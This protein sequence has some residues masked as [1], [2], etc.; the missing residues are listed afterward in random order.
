MRLRVML[1]TVPAILASVLALAGSSWYRIPLWGADVTSLAVDPREPQLVYCGTSRGNVYLSRDGGQ[2]WA[3]T[4]PGNQFPGYIVSSLRPDVEREGRLWAALAGA[5][6]GA[7]V[8]V[9]DDRGAGW[10]VLARWETSVNARAIAQSPHDPSFLACGGDDGVF[11]SHDGGK[12]WKPVGSG[13]VGLTLVQSLAFDPA[14]PLTLFA[15]TYR[16]AFR[17]RD[18]GETWSRIA[19]G[20]VLDATVYSWDFEKSVPSGLWV[21]TCGWVYH[22]PDSGDHWTRFV[23]GFTN[24]RTLVVRLDPLR[25]DV[26][27]AGTVGGLHRS[28]DGGKTWKRIT[29]D[30]LDVSALEVDPRSGRLLIGTLGEG[31]FYSD[32]GGES[33]HSAS[34]G[35]AEARIPALAADPARPS[36]V[37]FLRAYGGLESGVWE[38]DDG[39]SRK[40]S[41]D[42]PAGAFSMAASRAADGATIWMCASASSLFVS[43]DGGHHFVPPAK[44]PAGR[45]IQVFGDPLSRPVVVTDSGVYST[46]DGTMFSRVATVTGT[47]LSAD[48]LAAPPGDPQ[49][50]VRTSDGTFRQDGAV[51]A[52]TSRPRLAGGMFRKDVADGRPYF[53]FSV[54]SDTLTLHRGAERASVL[55]PR[56]ELKIS[57]AILAGDGTLYVATMGDGLFRFKPG[58]EGSTPAGGGAEA[59]ALAER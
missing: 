28:G 38:S 37:L 55:L 7:L 35:L 46:S 10:T 56:D 19:A 9:S 32:D 53:H 48:L 16:Q 41:S 24:R 43:L 45:V 18:G 47:P 36:R 31:M 13:V 33:M 59:R 5:D 52:R 8:A 15:G 4:R 54:D 3:P 40:I 27:Y 51:F 2:N 29:R 26:L 20:M 30:S 17:S 22:S 12:S 23:S 39:V 25:P 11:L 42:A 58:A 14:D 57:G 50:E 49:L 1:L 34:T 21:S 6:R 44:G